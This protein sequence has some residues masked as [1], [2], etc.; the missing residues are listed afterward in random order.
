[1]PHTLILGSMP[2]VQSLQREQYYANPRNAFWPIVA[3]LY[4]FSA[5]APYA[6][7]V[8]ALNTAGVAVWDVLYNCVRHGSLDS[9]IERATE[10][11]ND[12]RTFLSKYRS[13]RLIAFNGQAAQRIFMRHCKALTL[14]FKRLKITQLP[15]T[16]PAYAAMKPAQKLALW[17]R[18]LILKK[19]A[20]L[21]S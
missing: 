16:S 15:S 9:N 4:G 14:E 12:F 7:R 5:D 18:Q 19:R 21:D 6:D 17:E 13:L 11:P 2:S 3:K 20:Q 8:A 10:Q 1:M